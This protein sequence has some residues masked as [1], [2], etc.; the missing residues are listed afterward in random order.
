MWTSGE[1]LQKKWQKS[2]E[3]ISRKGNPSD[4]LMIIFFL[5]V[6]VAILN[7]SFQFWLYVLT[8]KIYTVCTHHC[9]Y[10]FNHNKYVQSRERERGIM[11]VTGV[12]PPRAEHRLGQPDMTWRVLGGL[13]ECLGWVRVRYSSLP[14]VCVS[15]GSNPTWLILN[16]KKKKNLFHNFQ[17][18]MLFFFI[19]CFY[20]NSNGL[21]LQYFQI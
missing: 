13:D 21:F 16:K 8:I 5:L 10:D 18:Q 6:L 7:F 1:L 4:L 19:Y 2:L 11:F 15:L 9:H 20:L 12:K 17:C 3:S 14:R